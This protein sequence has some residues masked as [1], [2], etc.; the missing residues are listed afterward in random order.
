MEKLRAAAW[1]LLPSVVALYVYW[2]GLFAWFQQDD[3]VWLHLLATVHSPHDLL[4]AL[5][6]PTDHGTW[7][8]IPERAFFLGFGWLFGYNAL[9]YRIVVFLTQCGN[10]ALIA[11]I[12]RRLSGSALA[13]VLASVLWIASSQLIVVM[14]WT[15]E[16]ILAAAGLCLLAA[17][18]LLL[19]YANTGERRYWGYCWLVFLAGFLMMETNIVFPLLAVSYVFLYARPIF[20]KTLTFFIPSV[21]YGLLHVVFVNPHGAGVYTMHFDLSIARTLTRYVGKA[22]EPQSLDSFTTFPSWVGPAGAV[23]FGVAL[24][25]FVVWRTWRRDWLPGLMV[26][27]FVFLLSPVLPL[28]DHVVPYY[29]TLPMIPLSMLGALAVAAAW[30]WRS[31]LP[32]AMGARVLATG[33][34]VFYLAESIPVARG[35][36]AW[37]AG[38]SHEVERLARYVFRVH[39][40]RPESI[41]VLRH[42]DSDLFWTGIAH[43]PFLDDRERPYVYLAGGADLSIEAHPETGF[44][45]ADFVY[46]AEKVQWGIANNRVVLIDVSRA[47]FFDVTAQ[48]RPQAP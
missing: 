15:S 39:R 22:F 36:T 44:Q 32:L 26:A 42:V 21:V 41:I 24:I 34:V 30:N 46:P 31:R 38:R 8:P 25:G 11:A 14:S 6:R 18:Y 9:P 5:F 19:R 23:M 3:F 12:T 48:F 2:A 35:G 28:R 33:L 10:L 27:W 7:R 43:Y 37:W 4:V 1:W 13:G 20:R 16:Y 45:V 47:G 40:R 17:F 29:L